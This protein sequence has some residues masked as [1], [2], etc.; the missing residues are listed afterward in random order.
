MPC[1]PSVT[2]HHDS[3]WPKRVNPLIHL[4]PFGALNVPIDVVEHIIDSIASSRI[5][6]PDERRRALYNCSLTCRA[7]LPRSQYHLYRSIHIKTVE[8][9]DRLAI[10]SRRPDAPRLFSHLRELIVKNPP[11]S[12][13]FLHL[14][15]LVLT[16]AIS[17]VKSL[18]IT[19]GPKSLQRIHPQAF[20]SMGLYESLTHLN[21][22]RCVFSTFGDL[23]RTICHFPV[24]VKLQLDHCRWRHAGLHQVTRKTMKPRLRSLEIVGL[25]FTDV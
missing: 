21:L 10:A 12:S 14:I 15:P 11:L 13:S 16:K 23:R 17:K 2:V 4:A 6:F 25:S 9:L 3:K 5:Y 20:F 22:S 24:L 8:Q 18:H 1:S 19:S 7:W